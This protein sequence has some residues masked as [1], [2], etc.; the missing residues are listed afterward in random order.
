M[1]RHFWQLIMSLR[2]MT[3]PR[4]IT[5]L[6]F[7][8]LAIALADSAAGDEIVSRIRRHPVQSSSVASAGYSRQLRALEIEFRRGAVYRFLDV[9]C[10]VD[11]AFAPP[12]P[13][14]VLSPSRFEGIIDSF[15]SALRPAAGIQNHLLPKRPGRAQGFQ[16]TRMW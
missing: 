10:E 14:A 5:S 7:A 4:Q 13:R 12:T 8:L 3:F 2:P 6:L 9:P 11:R 1:A 15:A 16:A